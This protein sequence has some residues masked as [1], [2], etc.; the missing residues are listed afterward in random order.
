MKRGCIFSLLLLAAILSGYYYLLDQHFD[1]PDKWIGTGVVGFM[2]F[3]G[4]GF[5]MNVRT[6]LQDLARINR[7]KSGSMPV[8]G[9]VIAAVGTI[10]PIGES[11]KAPFSGR[12]CALYEYRIFETV[13]SA[14]KNSGT[15]EVV[16][17]HGVA[18]TPS[19]IR[20]ATSGGIKL[21][22]YP[23]LEG[24]A[25]KSYGGAETTNKALAYIANTKFEDFT[26]FKL[27]KAVSDVKD[28]LTDDD[29]SVKK[30]TRHVQPD[31]PIDGKQFQEEIV[32]VG[33]EVCVFGRY[34]A[35]KGGL[36]PDMKAGVM[37]RMFNGNFAA[38]NR[39]L[40]QK[41]IVGV[42]FGIV[43]LVFSNAG[44]WL[45]LHNSEKMKEQAA[46]Q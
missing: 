22:G 9:S 5:L 34:S 10:H 25:K 32:A 46:Q 29:G 38:I 11:L 43:F 30:D 41:V 45:G 20:T 2:T 1:S 28:L 8:D 7:G 23:A 31:S 26:G 14:G 35:A 42:V 6:A 33:E 17:Y 36:V 16:S 15:T 24:F 19:E 13:R 18:M 4:I 21:L 3:F 37:N 39:T 40:K 27:L 44:L 12:D